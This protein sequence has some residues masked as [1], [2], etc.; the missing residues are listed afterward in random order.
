M[1]DDVAAREGGKERGIV[2]DVAEKELEGVAGGG[3]CG[4]VAAP[5]NEGT[6]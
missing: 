6:N 5:A 3:E 1:E 4:D 2:G